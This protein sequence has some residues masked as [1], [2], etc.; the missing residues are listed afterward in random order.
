MKLLSLL[1]LLAVTAALAADEPARPAKPEPPPHPNGPE[2]AAADLKRLTVADG[3]EAKLFASEPDVVNPCDMDVDHRGRV[4]ITEGANYRS[5]FQKWGTLRGGGDRIQVLEDTDGDGRADK[6]TTFYQDPSI[7]SALGICVLGNKVI[8]SS[9]PNVFVLTDTDGD[10]KAD[11]RELLFTDIKGADH[12]HAVHAFVFG[13]DGKFYFNFGNAGSQLRRPS[14]A[15]KDIPLHGLIDKEEMK[16][17]PMVVDLAGNQVTDKAKPYRQGMVFRCNLD[18]SEFEV[19]GHNFRNNYE[20]AVDSFGTLWQSDNDDDGFRGVR[21]NYVMEFGNF[22]YTDE[23]TGAG[24]RKVWDKARAN[25]AKEEE[26]PS[27]HWYQ[28]DPGVVP[29]LLQTGNGS[30]TGILVY[31]G[32]LLP[33]VFRNQMI[34]C[35]AGPRVVRAYPVTTNGAGYSATITN[36]LTSPDSWFRPSDACVGPDGAVYVA[37]W[38]DAN[39]GGHNMADL[40]LEA[41]TGRVYRLAPPGNKPSVPKFNLASP[42]GAVVALRSPNMEARYLAWTAL[43]QMGI[44]A[45]DELKSLWNDKNPRMRARALPL[46]A[47]LENGGQRYVLKA[48]QESDPDLRIAALRTAR[49]LKMD[50]VPLVHMLARDKSP[51]VRRECAIALRHHK[52]SEAPKL[53]ALLATQHTA[54]DRWYLEALGLSAD[55]Q[56]DAFFSAW[57]Q[58]VGN[59]WNTPEGRE[60][61]WRSRSTKVP[62]L[63]VKIVTDKSASTADKD[64]FMRTLDFIKGPE[65]DAALAEIATAALN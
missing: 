47:R 37:D 31:E 57:L 16:K 19:L 5:T 29:N 44:G 22:G 63:V 65:K 2:A 7:N 32:D 49:S 14:D 56:E 59:D 20:V 46:L 45:E 51:A 33:A 40:K 30:P 39:V 24:W 28:T 11:R 17:G 21:I 35:D 13:P 41:M 60:I 8:V 1:P 4:W 38:N 64:K 15:L 58:A 23:M 48:L 36:L 62:G 18:G 34:H 43:R 27:Y 53:W 10:G 3:V 52:S 50:A 12:D 6:A 26:T 54:G 42:A 55:G 25:G 61:V 9:S